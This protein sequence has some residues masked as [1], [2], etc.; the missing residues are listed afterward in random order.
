MNF[1]R[2]VLIALVAALAVVGFSSPAFAFHSGGVAECAGCHAMH[3]A[4]S[5]QYLLTKTDSSSVCLNCHQHAGDTGPSSYHVSTAE[6]DMPSG[7]APLQRNPGGD[8]GWLKKTYNFT[9]RGNPNTDEGQS[10]GHNIVAADFGYVAD[11]RHATGP[12][13]TFATADLRCGACHDPHGSYRRLADGTIVNHGPTIRNSGSYHN[14][15]DPT[16]TEAVGVY[17][18][19]YGVGGQDGLYTVNPPAAVAPS[20][21]NRTEATTDTRV[22]YGQGMSEWCGTCHGDMVNTLTGGTHT[23]PVGTA[24]TFTADIVNNYNNYVKTGDFSGVFPGARGGPY[25]SLVPF[26]EG[27]A[28]YA[29][30]KAHATNNGSY[31]IGPDVTSQATCLSCHRAHAS[32]W[33]YGLRWNGEYELLTMNTGTDPSYFTDPNTAGGR[34]RTTAEQSAAYYDRPASVFA[35]AQRSLCNKCHAKD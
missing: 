26:E 9:V 20:A 30:L 5:D 17:R 12:G 28:D 6:V 11:S 7:T 31:M 27:H 15:N 8:F 16:P 10:F 22:A 24:G 18:L 35:V 21:Y 23:H 33:M 29:L 14:S 19:L 32:G 25:T 1:P 13:G 34:G 4:Q 2:T 3:H